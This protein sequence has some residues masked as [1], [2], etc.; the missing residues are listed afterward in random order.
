[1]QL[2]RRWDPFAEATMLSHP[3]PTTERVEPTIL[4]IIAIEIAHLTRFTFLLLLWH[5]H[6][7][8]WAYAN[9]TDRNLDLNNTWFSHLHYILEY[10]F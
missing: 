5:N 10:N 7:I 3:E 4:S 2:P 1:L 6:V 8:T 9:N